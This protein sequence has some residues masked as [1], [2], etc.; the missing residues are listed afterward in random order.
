MKFG[1]KAKAIFCPLTL[2]KNYATIAQTKGKNFG[3]HEKSPAT[4][5]CFVFYCGAIDYKGRTS[6][7]SS[8]FTK[9]FDWL[10]SGD[11]CVNYPNFVYIIKGGF[12]FTTKF[13]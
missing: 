12:G 11:P 2:G 7:N 6:Q 13:L 5:Y 3:G 10:P 9:K 8:A 4:R 1:Y